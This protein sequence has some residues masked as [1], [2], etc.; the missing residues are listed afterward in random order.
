M[1]ESA[2]KLADG[3]EVSLEEMRGFL[4]EAAQ[5]YPGLR[6]LRLDLELIGM[7]KLTYLCLTLWERLHGARAGGAKVVGKFP[8][9]PPDLY[10]GCGVIPADP[11][12]HAMAYQVF[13]GDHSLTEEG[14][15]E[16]SPEACAWQAAANAAIRKGMV[17]LDAFYPF[18]GPW[19]T[20]T[21]Y[22]CENLLEVLPDAHFLDQ[23]F[24]P[25]REGK[26]ENA[27]D[28]MVKEIQAFAA[29][30][31][32]LTGKRTDM[33][34][35]RRAIRTGNALRQKMRRLKEYLKLEAVPFSALDFV[36]AGLLTDDWVADPMAS[37]DVLDTICQEVGERAAQGERGKGI[38]EDSARIF[39]CGITTCD[40]GVYNLLE[41]LGGTLVGLE[42]IWN[43][44]REDVAEEGDPYVGLAR[45][46][47][48]IPFTQPMGDR[49]AVIVDL[50]REWGVEG[51]IFD[52]AYGCNYISKTAR[53][54]CDVIKE[55][56]G[57]PILILDTDL[58]NEHR[59]ALEEKIEG[60]LEIVRSSRMR[61]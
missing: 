32:R 28:Y 26:E 16:L 15:A 52:C 3:R 24:F 39:F 31:E 53:Y 22:N 5:E 4:K 35:M 58:P 34:E 61:A 44:F 57:L 12:V 56:L 50:V 55:E 10:Y 13:T 40:L 38:Q 42:C 1:A 23:P 14:R 20:N 36:F 46:D 6:E 51:V 48:S 45:R 43:I 2:L 21:P 29:Q 27:L 17:P 59:K 9:N 47:L 18:I 41:D 54:V 37:W 33:E 49:S 25:H 11:F 60:F 8:A 19:C 7:V 30:M